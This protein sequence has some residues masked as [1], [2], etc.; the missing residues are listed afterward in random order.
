MSAAIDE[1]VK[2]RRDPWPD[3]VNRTFCGV[4]AV[5][6]R[7]HVGTKRIHRN[8]VAAN[9]RTCGAIEGIDAACTLYCRAVRRSDT[10]HNG[11]LPRFGSRRTVKDFR[12]QKVRESSR[13]HDPAAAKSVAAVH[14]FV[15]CAMP[16]IS[17]DPALCELRRGRVLLH[18]QVPAERNPDEST[19]QTTTPPRSPEGASD[20]KI[21]HE[22]EPPR[23]VTSAYTRSGPER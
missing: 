13:S 20:R 16:R 19:H 22:S 10:S 4:G 5:G 7:N 17:E 11:V 6:L 12:E 18:E 9:L 15:H 21:G 14:A 3:D 2:C 1:R 23:T 8:R